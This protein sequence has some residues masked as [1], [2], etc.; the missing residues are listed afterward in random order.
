MPYTVSSVSLAMSGVGYIYIS[1]TDGRSRIEFRR[2]NL[3]LFLKGVVEAL[4]PDYRASGG[5][6]YLNHRK[7]KLIQ[8]V[9]APRRDR[10]DFTPLTLDE[11]DRI[12]DEFCAKANAM[13]A[14]LNLF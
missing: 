5:T 11:L 6:G 3:S 4:K 2:K 1:P 9:V 8:K 12:A 13:G 7:A 10:D 14:P